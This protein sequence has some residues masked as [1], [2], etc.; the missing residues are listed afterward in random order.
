ML[1]DARR[2]SIVDARPGS[3]YASDVLPLPLK[4]TTRIISFPQRE[5]IRLEAI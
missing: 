1:V 5:D 4:V 3:T 2:C